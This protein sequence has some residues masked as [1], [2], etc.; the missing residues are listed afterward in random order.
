[1]A[2]LSYGEDELAR[3]VQSLT[4]VQIDKI[5]EIAKRHYVALGVP[6]R[7]TGPSNRLTGKVSKADSLAAVQIME[8]AP[9]P[10]KRERRLPYTKWFGIP[11]S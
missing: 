1:M 5:N 10:L 9:R 6:R 7:P 2:L 3:R 8:G 4:D 11:Q